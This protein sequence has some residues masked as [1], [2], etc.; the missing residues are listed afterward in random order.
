MSYVLFKV[1]LWLFPYSL[2]AQSWQLEDSFALALPESV[3]SSPHNRLYVAN[4]Q[5]VIMQYNRQGDT[6][7]VHQP[8]NLEVPFLLPWQTL[9]IQAYFPFQQMLTVLDQ[10]LSE[11]STISLPEITLGNATLSADQQVWYISADLI[12]NKYNPQLA[13]NTLSASLQWYFSSENQVHLLREYQNRIYIQTDEQ[14]LIFDLF[15]NFLSQRPLSSDHP[16]QFLN[17]EAYFL[18][19]DYIHFIHLYSGT[20]R[21]LPMPAEKNI[22]KILVEKEYLHGYSERFWYTYSMVDQNQE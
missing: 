20:I 7:R 2:S 18:S 4:A 16:I 15:G 8:S 9:R 1:S 21:Q 11:V 17:D 13:E 19:G 22:R 3:A 5:G 14:L 10:N 6:L 12:L